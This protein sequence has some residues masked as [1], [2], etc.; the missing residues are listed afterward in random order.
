[1]NANTSKRRSDWYVIA[2]VI[3]LLIGSYVGGYLLL[4][5]YR[6]WTMRCLDSGD[7][8]DHIRRDFKHSALAEVFAPMGWAEAKLRGVEVVVSGPDGWGETYSR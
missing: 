8:R 1:M 7:L 4:G 2:A 3:L 5:E 6:V